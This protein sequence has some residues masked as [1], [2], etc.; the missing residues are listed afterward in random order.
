MW[1]EI[2]HLLGGNVITL[3]SGQKFTYLHAYM[4]S[5]EFDSSYIRRLF[6][7]V[8]GIQRYFYV[9]VST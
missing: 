8:L 1:F 4:N 9:E 3:N 6:E 7:D 5:P 2:G